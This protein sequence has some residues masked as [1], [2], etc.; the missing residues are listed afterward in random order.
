MNYLRLAAIVALVA[1]G[2][3]EPS[4]LGQSRVHAETRQCPDDFVAFAEE[5]EPLTCQCRA[6]A[7]Q[8]G[9]VWGTDVYTSDSRICRAALHAGA[10]PRLGGPVTVVPESGRSA[11]PGTTRLGVASYDFGPYESSFRFGGQALAS[12]PSAS[13]AP[14]AA[15]QCPD[16]F[17]AFQDDPAPLVCLCPAEAM[18]RGSLWGT[19][20]YTADSSICQAALHAGALTRLGGE[21]SVTGEPGRRSYAGTTRNGLSS[22]DFG[23]SEASFRVKG[24]AIGPAAPGLPVQAA[25]GTALRSSGHVQLYVQFRTGSANLDVGSAAVLEELASVM[26]SDPALRLT[27]T[28]HTD[29]TGTPGGNRTLSLRRAE[30]VQ[31]WLVGRGISATRLASD[32]HG[33][34]EPIAPDRKSTRLN[35]SHRR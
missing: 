16:D 8:R 11:Y 3:A 17:V 29:S 34:D 13:A 5:T 19:D 35:S 6:E 27:L 30:A 31:G 33:Q 28:G 2:M 32:G 21:V 20:V 12:V 14:A 18:G 26:A 10:V 1:L 22:Y 4:L 9:E 24:W 7:T 23:P 15:Q 25:I